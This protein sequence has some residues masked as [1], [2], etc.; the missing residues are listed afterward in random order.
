MKVSQFIILNDSIKDTETL[1]YLA[2][3]E[4]EHPIAKA[5]I[6]HLHSKV[7]NLENYNLESFDSKTGEG[8][9]SIIKS[10]SQKFEVIVGNEK[11]IREENKEI[12]DIV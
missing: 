12:H 6:N 1:V 3:Q 7:S 11:M 9:I 2:E 5:I 4:S 10:K 8:V